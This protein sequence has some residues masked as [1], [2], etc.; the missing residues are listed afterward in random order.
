MNRHI[1]YTKTTRAWSEDKVDKLVNKEEA[2]AIL[3]NKKSRYWITGIHAARAVLTG[4]SNTHFIHI[5]PV[6]DQK[7][8][9]LFVFSTESIY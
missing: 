8:D 1:R 9:F 3:T 6:K 2:V 5:S 4:K 7:R